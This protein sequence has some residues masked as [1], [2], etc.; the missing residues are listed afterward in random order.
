[1]VIECFLFGFNKI[2]LKRGGFFVK[3]VALHIFKILLSLMLF[4]FFCIFLLAFEVYSAGTCVSIVIPVYNVNQNLLKSCLNSVKNQTLEN[5]EIICVDDGSTDGSGKILDEYAKNDSRFKIYHQKNS[6]PSAAR[7]R[8]IDLSEG[9]YIQ[10]VDSDDHMSKNMSE[11]LY[12]LAKQ[13][14]ADIVRCRFYSSKDPS[15]TYQNMTYRGPVFGVLDSGYV[16][17]GLYK[18][19]LLKENNLRFDELSKFAEDLS[20]N[21]ICFPKANKIACCFDK[22]YYYTY[23]AGSLTRM[24]DDEKACLSLAENIDFVYKNWKING[25]FDDNAARA[26]FFKWVLRFDSWLGRDGTC[27]LFAKAIGPELLEDSVINLLPV[28]E[29]LVFRKM[30]I[31]C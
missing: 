31:N 20:F 26:G 18:S 30:K 24:R 11:K 28:K 27:G 10:F 5:I 4:V 29:R 3:K 9:E 15:I 25:Y 12:N 14:D 1:M 7:N 8:G 21:M 22:L 16:W 23:N 2:C 13:E 6:G 19:S 17:N